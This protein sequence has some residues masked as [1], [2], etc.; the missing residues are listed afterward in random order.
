MSSSRIG[1]YNDASGKITVGVFKNVS[2]TKADIQ[3]NIAAEVD[4][5][6]V[7]IG[8]GAVASD[9]NPG[10]LLTASYPNENRSAWLASSK[11]HSRSCEHYLTTYA[12]GLKIEG[13][14]LEEL[15]DLMHIE[16]RDSDK[17]NHPE[18]AAKVPY[19]YNVVSGGFKIDWAG[20]GNLATASFPM[21]DGRSWMAKSKDHIHPDTAI[22]HV[23]AIGLPKNLPVG[24]LDVSYISADSSS[25]NH[26]S[27]TAHV[28]H[29]FALVG[30]GGEAHWT[31][32]GSLLWRL[33]PTVN[34]EF[35]ASSKDHEKE[36]K[37]TI[38][39]HAVGIRIL[40]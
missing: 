33:E 18:V 34:K 40:K 27:C 9:E 38:T 20:F 21:S 32:D 14:S 12:L 19:G 25:A 24:N 15:L 23:F 39:A 37:C 36:D 26:P 10:A 30:G 8:G 1:T 13:I 5:D 22:L 29:S 7:V 11:A 16:I 6:M 35:T 28:D 17:V 2:P 3:T 31:S 4:S